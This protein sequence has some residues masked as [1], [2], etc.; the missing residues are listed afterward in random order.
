MRRSLAEI[1][2]LFKESGLIWALSKQSLW[3]SI[4]SADDLKAG[5]RNVLGIKL[6]NDCSLKHI[7]VVVIYI[8]IRR[9]TD[10]TLPSDFFGK[11]PDSGS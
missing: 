1:S 11:I 4:E 8:F 9:R 7:R 2:A 5:R 10:P 3:Q 6:K